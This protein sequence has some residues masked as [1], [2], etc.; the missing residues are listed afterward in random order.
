MQLSAGTFITTVATFTLLTGSC[1]SWATET[2]PLLNSSHDGL[3]RSPAGSPENLPFFFKGLKGT[4][5]LALTYVK[6]FLFLSLTL[7]DI[8][9]QFRSVKTTELG[10]CWYKS[11][12]L[13]TGCSLWEL[14]AF[15]TDSSSLIQKSSNFM[16]FIAC[17]IVHIFPECM[18]TGENCECG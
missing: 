4:A 8:L 5:Q 7:S 2:H 10:P 11:E 3:F 14:K 12:E 16:A 1:I 9:P 6:E 18:K 17:C 15:G 13:L